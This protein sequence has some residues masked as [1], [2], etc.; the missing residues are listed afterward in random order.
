MSHSILCL[1][2]CMACIELRCL[3][4]CMR[5]ALVLERLVCCQCPK[6]LCRSL[7]QWLRGSGQ[8][9]QTWAIASMSLSPGLCA[10]WQ[11][12]LSH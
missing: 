11:V 2:S 8:T 7:L 9:C 5:S 10:T 12:L 3:L 6:L 4:C 1:A